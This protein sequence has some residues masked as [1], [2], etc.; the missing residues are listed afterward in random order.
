LDAIS[1]FNRCW[2]D[3]REPITVEL[4]RISTVKVRTILGPVKLAKSGQMRKLSNRTSL[5]PLNF[6]QSRGIAPN[7]SQSATE[8]REYKI[9]HPSQIRS[10]A[11]F[12]LTVQQRRFGRVSENR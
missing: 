6:G 11:T 12:G 10:S 7:A 2:H 8:A 9:I 3:G 4:S 5:Y 1:Q